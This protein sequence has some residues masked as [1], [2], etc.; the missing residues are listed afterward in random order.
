IARPLAG[1]VLRVDALDISPAMIEAGR[2]RPGGDQPNLHWILGAAETAELV[3]PYALV[4]AGASLRWM[5]WE[6]T[7]RR[8]AGLMTPDARLAVVDHGPSDVPWRDELIEVIRRHSRSR[9]YDPELDI[10]D[11]LCDR[12]LLEPTGSTETAPVTFR[13]AVGDYVESFHARAALARE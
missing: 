9:A 3:G 2:R 1:R 10:V 13:Q 5:K 4:T 8:L 6:P 12:G 7:M 11:A